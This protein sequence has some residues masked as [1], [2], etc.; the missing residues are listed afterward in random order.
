[1][2]IDDVLARNDGLC[3]DDVFD[4][5]KLSKAIVKFYSSR[6]ELVEY[7]ALV[8]CAEMQNS[9]EIAEVVDLLHRMARLLREGK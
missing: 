2:T 3:M 1:M 6:S 5:A 9:F 4:R 7:D 8:E